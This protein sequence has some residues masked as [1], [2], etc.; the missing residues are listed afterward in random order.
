[1]R[2]LCFRAPMQGQQYAYQWH[3][4]CNAWV[5]GA[6]YRPEYPLKCSDLAQKGGARTFLMNRRREPD[7]SDDQQ[8]EL[9][10]LVSAGMAAHAH[11]RDP[12]RRDARAAERFA[13]ARRAAAAVA[14]DPRSL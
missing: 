10:I 11:E 6:I 13:G 4:Y 2:P 14:F 8:Q 7:D 12:V 9:F 1:M 5:K 3:D